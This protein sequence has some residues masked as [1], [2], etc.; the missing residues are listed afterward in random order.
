[1]PRLTLTF[2]NGPTPG[3]TESVLDALEAAEVRATFFLVGTQ[4]V[5]SGARQLAERA[6]SAGH[7]LGSHTYSHGEPL[8]TQPS[9]VIESEILKM[10]ALM[11]DLAGDEMLFR[12]NGKGRVGPHL[13]SAQAVETLTDLRAT[14]VLWTSVPKDRAAVVDS[15]KAWLADAE[16]AVLDSDWTLMVLHDRPSGFPAPGPMA[17]LPDFLAWAKD[18]AEIVQEFPPACTPMRRGVPGPD[19]ARFVTP[20]SAAV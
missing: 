12:P 13:L 1:M 3:I 9:G 2:D 16:R 4:L 19:L 14:V 8:G 6:L 18:T 11:G 20:V 7:R 15:P 10:H 5:R 17:F